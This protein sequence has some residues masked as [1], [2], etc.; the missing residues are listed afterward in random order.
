MGLSGPADPA[1]HTVTVHRFYVPETLAS[2]QRLRLPDEEASHLTRSLRLDVGALIRVFDGRGHE[3]SARIDVIGRSG[4]VVETQSPMQ[5]AR[6]PRVALTLAQAILTGRH[7]DAIV[8]DATMLGVTT[9]QPLVTTYTDRPKST[10]RQGG[11]PSRWQRVAIA[12]AK[13]SGRAHVPVVRKIRSFDE[14]LSHLTDT[15]HLVLVEPGRGASSTQSAAWRQRP[16]PESATLSVGPEGGW[17]DAELDQAAE[18][19]ELLTLGPRTF[20]A[21]TAPIVALSV[22]QFLW[23]DL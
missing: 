17:T 13:Q 4:V 16:A 7:F 20:R 12:S 10:L 1:G 6:E 15:T 19:G 3:Y 18:G 2:N 9:I 23:G 8:R 14:H 5:A 11:T 22:L 21:E